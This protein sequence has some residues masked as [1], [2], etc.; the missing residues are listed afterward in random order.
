MTTSVAM[1][2][3]GA[4]VF[5]QNV[6]VCTIFITIRKWRRHYKSR[7][8]WRSLEPG[9]AFSLPTKALLNSCLRYVLLDCGNRR[10]FAACFSATLTVNWKEDIGRPPPPPPRVPPT[11]LNNISERSTST[12]HATWS[13]AHDENKFGWPASLDDRF[14]F[15]PLFDV[16]VFLLYIW[17]VYTSNHAG[18]NKLSNVILQNSFQNK[19]L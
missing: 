3:Y 9:N 19:Q 15:R 5:N 8:H 4:T 12:S 1:T 18:E 17:F 13:L 16:N 14:V 6:Y 10:S 2:S 11:F 7:A